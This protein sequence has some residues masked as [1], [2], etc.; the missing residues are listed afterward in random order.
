MPTRL[1]WRGVAARILVASFL[2]AALG[3]VIATVI[4]M[5]RVVTVA[6]EGASMVAIGHIGPQLEAC[7]DDPARWSHVSTAGYPIH[8]YDTRTGLSANPDAPPLDPRLWARLQAGEPAPA[9]FF[10]SGPHGGATVVRVLEGGPCSTYQLVWDYQPARRLRMMG[11]V[12]LVLLVFGSIGMA[13]PL[14]VAV[15]PLV[16]RIE[17]A[18]ERAARVGQAQGY[19]PGQDPGADAISALS[20]TLDGLNARV[21]ADAAELDRRQRAVLEHI[22]NLSHDLR[23]PIQSLH[24]A[25]DELSARLVPASPE[26]TR[27][28]TGTLDDVVWLGALTEN[29]HLSCQLRE[30]AHPLAGSPR[31]E[32]GALVDRAITRGALLGRAHRIAV[33]GARPDAPVCL[34]VNPVMMEQV[35]SNLVRN[36][37]LHNTPG[38]SVAVL[39]ETPAP[40]RFELS[41]LDDG[42]GVPPHE[43]PRLEERHFRGGEAQDRG[44]FGSGLGLAIVGEICR[45]AGLELELRALDPRGLGVIVRGP[46]LE[47]HPC[48]A[49][50]P[51]GDPLPSPS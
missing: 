20:R 3:S 29:L 21:L 25:L 49:Q 13:I 31:C 18:S 44:V 10:W 36:A 4:A 14:L 26:T 1:L 23:T 16:R 11:G 28:L 9:R 17:A 40:G 19:V 46:T 30:G 51:G 32:L 38:G 42:P 43:L 12:F 24:L 5:D 47:D 7:L 45:L 15:R 33:D 8:A 6:T 22:G 39:L 41:V 37:V 48:A 50:A 27:L 34:G 35:L 2:C